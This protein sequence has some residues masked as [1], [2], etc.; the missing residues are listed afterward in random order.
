LTIG[1][2]F[3]WGKD[4]IVF[5]SVDVQRKIKGNFDGDDS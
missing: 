3:S 2:R 1:K 5:R 4:N